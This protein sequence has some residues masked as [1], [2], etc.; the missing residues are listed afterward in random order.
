MQEYKLN[1]TEHVRSVFQPKPESLKQKDTIERLQLHLLLLISLEKM[2]RKDGQ[3]DGES[4]P[5]SSIKVLLCSSIFTPWYRTASL[6]LMFQ[7]SVRTF[8]H[9]RASTEFPPRS[10]LVLYYCMFDGHHVHHIFKCNCVR[11]APD[12]SGH[13]TICFSTEQFFEQFRR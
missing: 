3:D 1:P 2:S 8:L 13:L 10:L 11:L 7:N 5:T 9:I 4:S 12:H 6:A